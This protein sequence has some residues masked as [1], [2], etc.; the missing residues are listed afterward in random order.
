[1]KDNRALSFHQSVSWGWRLA[2]T[3]TLSEMVLALPHTKTRRHEDFEHTAFVEKTNK[4]LAGP[5]W[6]KYI[7]GINAI[8]I[9]YPIWESN[10]IRTLM[11]TTLA[12]TLLAGLAAPAPQSRAQGR[13]FQPQVVLP[14]DRFGPITDIPILAGKDTELDDNELVLGVVVGGEARAYPINMLTGPSRE[15]LNDELGGIAIA[16]T[17]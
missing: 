12:L 9:P 13:D 2:W 15:I 17:W 3:R 1:M 7:Q 14:S 6:F 8:S 16:A 4:N 10:M 5:S 11:K